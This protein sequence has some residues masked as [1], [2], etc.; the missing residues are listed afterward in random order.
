MQH[1]HT[2]PH[3]IEIQSIDLD[4]V[5]RRNDYPLSQMAAVE[6][7]KILDR[8]TEN[9][10]ADVSGKHTKAVA[11]SDPQ[12]PPIPGIVLEY[13]KDAQAGIESHILEVKRMMA[14][15]RDIQE[16]K[17][18]QALIDDAISV[19]QPLRNAVATIYRLSELAP[20]HAAAVKATGRTGKS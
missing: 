2:E 17:E 13:V 15:T 18:L 3:G 16:K 8:Q 5:I 6:L 9:L 4:G 1:G 19:S 11:E 20:P 7:K 10:K 14:K 12:Y